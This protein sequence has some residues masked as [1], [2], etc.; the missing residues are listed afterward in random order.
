MTNSTTSEGRLHKANF[1]EIKEDRIQAT[2][3][4][5]VA[6]MHATHYITLG[7]REY[8][9]WFPGEANAVANSLSCNDDRTDSELNNLFCMHC[10]SQIPE[11]FV[12]QPLPNKITSWLTALLIRLPVKL[13][14][15]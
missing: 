4:L 2:V 15:Q 7:I 6:M 11:H 9:Q 8:S 5:E 3:R 12:I 13:Q 10:P 1:S 14:L